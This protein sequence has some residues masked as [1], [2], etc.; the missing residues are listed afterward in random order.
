MRDYSTSGRILVHACDSRLG[1]A[2]LNQLK[3]Y[4]VLY[5]FQLLRLYL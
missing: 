3:G 1:Q 5:F 4:Q 2:A